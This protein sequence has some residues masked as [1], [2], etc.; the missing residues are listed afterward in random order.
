MVEPRFGWFAIGALFGAVL[1]GWPWHPRFSRYSR[2]GSNPPPPGRKPAPPAGPH[3]QPLAAQLIRYWA[4]EQEQVR[5]AWLDPALG[6]PWPEG[7]K[8]APPAGLPVPPPDVAAAI[9]RQLDRDIAIARRKRGL[10]PYGWGAGQLNPP[11]PAPGMRR[12]YLWCPTSMAECGGPCW[13]AQDP[14]CCDCGA[15]WRDVPIRMDEGPTQR[16]NNSGGPTTPK[17]PIKPQ[18]TGPRMVGDSIKPPADQASVPPCLGKSAKISYDR[19]HPT[20]CP[21]QPRRP[22]GR[23]GS[24]CRWCAAVGESVGGSA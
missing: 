16:G 8:P 22:G 24:G 7:R 4:W 9:N 10:S 13:E 18:P 11:P 21:T 17:P 6:E 1:F 12:E 20:P 5:R 14:R 23:A 2:R 15:L 3:E 19:P